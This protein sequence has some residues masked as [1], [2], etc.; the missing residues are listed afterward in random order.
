M[1]LSWNALMIFPK[2][3]HNLRTEVVIVHPR[4]LTAPKTDKPL[5]RYVHPNL[6]KKVAVWS[7]GHMIC[8]THMHQDDATPPLRELVSM[9][10]WHPETLEAVGHGK[11]NELVRLLTNPLPTWITSISGYVSNVWTR[12]CDWVMHSKNVY[13]MIVSRYRRQMLDIEHLGTMEPNTLF[14]KAVL[15]STKCGFAP[16]LGALGWL[17]CSN[18]L[19]SSW[20]RLLLKLLHVHPQLGVCF[21]Y[22][23]LHASPLEASQSNLM[24]PVVEQRSDTYR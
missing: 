19:G 24:Q 1:V 5:R 8:A 14:G 4:V 21:V 10:F 20:P 13:W 6:V 7:I 15:W 23:K 17:D 16:A 12:W 18:L 2:I 9:C 11:G 22:L 3:L